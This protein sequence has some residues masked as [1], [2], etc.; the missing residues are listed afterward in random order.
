MLGSDQGLGLDDQHRTGLARR[1]AAA[2]LRSASQISPRLGK[3]V[4]LDRGEFRVDPHALAADFSRGVAQAPRPQ[5]RARL[6]VHLF[7]RTPDVRSPREPQR[8]GVTA[9]GLKEIFG[10]PGAL[11][12]G[13][14]GDRR[15]LPARARHG[16]RGALGPGRL[17][18]ARQG[19][20]PRAPMKQYEV[21]WVNLPASLAG[22]QSPLT[23]L[24]LLTLTTPRH[25]RTPTAERA[26]SSSTVSPRL[27]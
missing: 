12:A 18:A 11:G 25:G 27:I 13:R 6:A 19:P 4:S 15:S 22:T 16:A 21:R 9:R 7:E 2:G 10:K 5:A 23:G 20:R 17:G 26:H 1:R 3:G 24:A 8:I 14:T